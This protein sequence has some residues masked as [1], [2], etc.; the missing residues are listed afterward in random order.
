VES[1]SP[2]KTYDDIKITCNDKAD[3]LFFYRDLSLFK[4]HTMNTDPKTLSLIV[5]LLL[6]G[7]LS[8]RCWTPPNPA[9]KKPYY[10]DRVG[11]WLLSQS[12]I[13]GRLFFAVVSW[14]H[15]AALTLTYPHPPKLLCPNPQNLT[16]G[17]FTWSPF[18]IVSLGLIFIVAPIRLLAFKQLGRNFTFQLAKPMGLVTTG[19]YAYVQHPSYVGN[20]TIILVNMVMMFAPGGPLGCWLPSAVTEWMGIVLAVMVA[21]AIWGL[22]VRVKDEEEMLRREFGREWEVWHE[23]TKRFVPGV[24]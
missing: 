21:T 8:F 11:A 16:P 7:Y 15:C 22:F 18:M 5:G 9:P 17:H 20:I 14:L 2:Y 24:F 10:N 3:S 1:K 6:A 12:Y 19:L 23:K 4:S 13:S